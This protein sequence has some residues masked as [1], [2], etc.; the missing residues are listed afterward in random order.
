VDDTRLLRYV[1]ATGIME[2]RCRKIWHVV[3]AYH[4]CALLSVPSESIAE[5]VGSVLRDA[6]TKAAGRPKSVDVFARAAH[7]RFAGLRGHG[8]EEGVLSDALNLHFNGNSPETWHFK[9]AGQGPAVVPS[10]MEMKRGIRQQDQ[11]CW[12][13]LPLRQAAA[14][15]MKLSKFLPRLADLFSTA[16]G[17]AKL[18][19]GSTLPVGMSKTSS[20]QTHQRRRN[21]LELFRQEH[22]PGQLPQSLWRHLGANIMSIATNHRPGVHGR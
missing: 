20:R 18:A 12:I 22:T 15:E 14:S 19:S 7:I 6:A 16:F 3:R 8:G 13:A 11:P 2:I 5:T 17:W 9:K 21:D 4:R 10:R 1:M